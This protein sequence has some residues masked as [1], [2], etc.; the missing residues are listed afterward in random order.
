MKLGRLSFPA[1]V[2]GLVVTVEEVDLTIDELTTL[3]K[4]IS[5]L[6][7]PT[8][9]APIV[10]AVPYGTIDCEYFGKCVDKY[11]KCQDCANNKAKSYYQPRSA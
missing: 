7:H 8:P 11:S 9:L 10:Q 2:S 3:S 6:T 1:S 4:T 5:D